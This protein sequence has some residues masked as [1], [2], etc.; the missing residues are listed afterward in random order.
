MKNTFRKIVMASV[1]MAAIVVGTSAASAESTVKV[2]FEFKVG[3]KVCPAGEY[4][5]QGGF[6]HNLVMLKNRD[7]SVNFA[8]VS[9]PADP[10]GNFKATLRFDQVG[11]TQLLKSVQYGSQKTPVIDKGSKSL[12]RPITEVIQGQ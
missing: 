10:N 7:A 1:A 6:N 2:P 4:V 3:N 8:W 11:D 9:M 5:I 12:E